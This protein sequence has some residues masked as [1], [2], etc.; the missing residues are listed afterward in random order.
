MAR[1][2]LQYSYDD[3]HTILS[4]VSAGGDEEIMKITGRYVFKN[5]G[6]GRCHATCE[7]DITLGVIP[8]NRLAQYAT[9]VLMRS[10]MKNF[11][12]FA[13]NSR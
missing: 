6:P 4:W 12:K 2:V 7:L 8:S 11:R 3:Q 13:E 5:A 10:E 9:S 1:Y